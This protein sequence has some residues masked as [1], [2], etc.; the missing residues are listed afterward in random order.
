MPT[1]DASTGTTRMS[2]LVAEHFD[3]VAQQRHAARLGMWIFLGTEVMFFGGM[4]NAYVIYRHELPEAFAAASRHLNVWLGSINTAVL[5]GSSLLMALA[6]EAARNGKRRALLA[7]LGATIALGTVFLAIKF[8][9]YY[10]KYLNHHLPVL[11]FPFEVAGPRLEQERL[12]FG[13]Y[14]AMTGFHALHMLIG[15]GLM[16]WLAGRAWRGRFL[17]ERS[18]PVE[19]CGLYWHFVDIVWIFLFPLLY[20]IDRT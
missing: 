12:F 10:Q 4:F 14:L 3:D 11:G 7:F 1:I 16:L 18:Q 8:S 20:L 5:L 19:I 17:G 9:E 13:L 2:P 15:I 6:V